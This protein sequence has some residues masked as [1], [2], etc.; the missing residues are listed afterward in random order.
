M[1]DVQPT[2]PLLFRQLCLLAFIAG[3]LAFRQP[4]MG[5]FFLFILVYFDH[6]RSTAKHTFF[7]I[8]F[9]FILGSGYNFLRSPT[10]V[11]QPAWLDEALGSN[12]VSTTKPPTAI[13][14]QGRIGTVTPQYGGRVRLFLH[15]AIPADATT[16]TP[17]KGTI[18]VSLRNVTV[19]PIS[20]QTLKAVMRLTPIRSMKNPG[21][22]AMEEYWQDREV[23]IRAWN[24]GKKQPLFDGKGNANARLH[25]LLKQRF[26]AAAAKAALYTQHT[27]FDETSFSLQNENSTEKN[28]STLPAEYLSGSA[29]AMLPALIFGDRSYLSPKQNEL[30]AHSTLAHSLSLSG[31]HLGYA[32]ALGLCFSTI[33]TKI[34]PNILLSIPRPKLT[35][36]FALPI[37]AIYAWLGEAPISLLRA[38]CMLCFWAIL[39]FTNKP[40]ALLDGLII[41][42][43]FLLLLNPISLF[44]ISLQLSALS[45]A[46]IALWLPFSTRIK[47]LFFPSSSTRS[48]TGKIAL[49]LL[50]LS[51]VIQ[52]AMTPLLLRTFGTVG[53]WFPLNLLWLPLLGAI[54]MPFAF[55][56]LVFSSLGMPFL[57]VAC[58]SVA[59]IP[60]EGLM[61]LLQTMDNADILSAPA[62]MRPHWL[63]IAGWWLLCLSLPPAFLRFLAVRKKKTQIP[64]PTIQKKNSFPVYTFI[65]CGVALISI[66][67]LIGLHAYATQPIGL[68]LLDVGQG[69]AVLLEWPGGR[70]LIDGGGFTSDTFDVGKAITAPALTDNRPAKITLLAHTHPDNDHMSGLMYLLESF[71]VTSYA[72]NGDIPSG[73]LFSRWQKALKSASLTQQV[74]KAGDTIALE[75]GLRLEVLWPPQ[76]FT[77]VV[78][79][80]GEETN[81]SSLVL[82]LMLKEYPL[83][84]LCGDVGIPVLETLVKQYP[85]SLKADILLLPH[86]GSATGLLPAFYQAVQPRFA[87]ASCGFQNQWGFPAEAVQKELI[88]QGIPLFTTADFGQIYIHWDASFT[89]KINIPR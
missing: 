3:I 42:A 23:S 67:T 57:A 8:V 85:E 48:K 17:Y 35:I 62:I 80:R 87:L 89:P 36:L 11:A 13:T 12:R 55:A 71:S 1:S 86:H 75:K 43:V 6:P 88:H 15:E 50:M 52:I 25:S 46:V 78:S 54:V 64:T 47:K 32:V 4:I 18:L 58:L 33:F 61:M 7:L 59:N 41:A 29:A 72:G 22:W 40:K 83:A 16:Q 66:P 5:I 79:K 34:S 51:C 26:L 24:I 30:I 44:D 31:L 56:G 81:N 84:L 70:A 37:A 53:V 28:N 68:R 20:G 82:R 76:R 73:K 19:L 39:L 77:P 45:V 21:T 38:G 9:F 69:Q 63:A 49:E 60:C 65:I 2:P 27:K 14:L 10:V 74:W